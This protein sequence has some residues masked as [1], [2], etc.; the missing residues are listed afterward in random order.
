MIYEIGFVYIIASTPLNRLV[1]TI[2]D[3]CRLSFIYLNSYELINLHIP[4]PRHVN[5]S[6]HFSLFYFV[7]DFP[8]GAFFRHSLF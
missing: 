5:L 3:N 1:P 2:N 8:F 7:G 6:S 4:L